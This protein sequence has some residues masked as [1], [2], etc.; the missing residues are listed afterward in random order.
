MNSDLLPPNST[1]QE[2]AL[3][4]AV[5]RPARVP[6]RTLWDPR[7]CPAGILPWLA[8]ALSVDEWDSTWSE[9][10]KRTAIAESVEFHRRKGTIGALRKALERLGYEVEID[11]QTGQAYTF[12]L[13]FKVGQGA[14][15]GALL[16]A[17]I[18]KATEIALRQKN[19][20]SELIGSVYMADNNEKAGPY[21]AAAT[22]SGSETDV[23]EFVGRDG[24][25]Q[26]FTVEGIPAIDFQPL[27]LKMVEK[28][29]D[30]FGFVLLPVFE[31]G[32]FGS[33]W[34]FAL[35]M[36][37]P[38][39]GW[40]LYASFNGADTAE[41]NSG[42]YATLRDVPTT[43]AL[44]LSWNPVG[45]STGTPVLTE[46]GENVHPPSI[47]LTGVFLPGNPVFLRAGNLNGRPYY[48]LTGQ[49]WPSGV[50]G[51]GIV[52]WSG[53]S[54]PRWILVQSEIASVY[55]ESFQNVLSP[56]LVNEWNP[57]SLGIGSAPPTP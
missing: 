2:R 41:W 5:D 16:D 14:A 29:L 42:P 18:T 8:W 45:S 37:N 11:E 24:P 40:S 10:E 46:I 28:R 30:E 9:D 47:R 35:Y 55:W 57:I 23:Q 50:E 13:L 17:A 43:P 52:Y 6:T 48:T 34:Y 53:G 49:T 19:A 7:T 56:D 31:A 39:T 54:V 32:V 38:A 51:D 15:G 36:V 1:P 4:L 25:P 3:S 12:R 44:V 20:R 22:L 27:T 33:G 21:V 26:G